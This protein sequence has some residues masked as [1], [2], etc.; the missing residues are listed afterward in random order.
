[1]L[2]SQFEELKQRLSRKSP[3]SEVTLTT[4][5]N[6]G[7]LIRISGIELDGGWNRD[8][9]DILFVAPPGYPNSAPDCFWVEPSGFRL[10][11]GVTPQN[12]N[13]SNPIPGDNQPG[14][15]TTWFSWHVQ[16]WNPNRNSLNSFFQLVTDRLKP[17]R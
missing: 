14:R 7:A 11:N 9:A 15:T 5:S 12:S 3:A 16:G 8:K 1:M 2:Q 10:A 13:D 17:A 6:G 4:M